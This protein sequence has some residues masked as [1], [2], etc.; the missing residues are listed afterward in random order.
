VHV[1]THEGWRAPLKPLGLAA[2]SDGHNRLILV[3]GHR[4]TVSI[5][6]HGQGPLARLLLGDLSRLDVAEVIV[7]LNVPEDE[8][9]LRAFSGRLL[10]IIRNP[11]PKGF[12]AN[13]NAAFSRCSTPWFAV[14]NPDLRLPQNPFGS[15]LATASN[16]LN[17]GVVAPAIVDPAGAMEDS[18]RV[19]PTLWSVAGRVFNRRIGRAEIAPNA[20]AGSEF[21][22]LAGMFLVFSSGAFRRVGGFDERFFL[23]YEDY[24]VCAR[25]RRSGFAIAVDRRVRAV[26]EARRDSRRSW[27]HF[28]WHL[29]SLLR[30][31][32]SAIFWRLL[33][34]RGE[35]R[36]EVK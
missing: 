10:T 27:R 29:A 32:T 25:L 21:Y 11:I 31:W 33:F 23:Y 5:V 14:L 35:V 8:G 22:W 13:H 4:V 34:S 1:Q 7:T 24:D 18:V 9:F 19:N 26:H 12:G 17:P 6:S 16:L 36:M 3:S 15:L 30:V 2:Q 28:R 20:P